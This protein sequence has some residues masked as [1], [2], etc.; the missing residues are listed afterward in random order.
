MEMVQ[1][2]LHS[3][4]INYATQRNKNNSIENDE[5]KKILPFTF[6]QSTT[7]HLKINLYTMYRSAF[8]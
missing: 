6:M 8:V 3:I 5:E 1:S 2:Q 7:C 4:C